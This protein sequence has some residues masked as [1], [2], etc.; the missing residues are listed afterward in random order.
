M[1][2]FTINLKVQIKTINSS[3]KK[4]QENDFYFPETEHLIK[5]LN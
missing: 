5:L 4:G 1:M 2:I 3:L